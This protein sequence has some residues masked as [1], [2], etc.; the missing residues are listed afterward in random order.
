MF[1]QIA[2]WVF[3]VTYYRVANYALEPIWFLK[4][5]VLPIVVLPIVLVLTCIWNRIAYEGVMLL[6]RLFESQRETR[7]ELCAATSELQKLNASALQNGNV[8][9]KALQ[10]MCDRL[11]QICDNTEKE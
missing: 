4:W 7:T 3:F 2:F 5:M 9:M 1:V 6:F 10:Y 11:A 8:Q